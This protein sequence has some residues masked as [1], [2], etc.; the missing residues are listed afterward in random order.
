LLWLPE[1]YTDSDVQY[2]W[3]YS[4]FLIEIIS[5]AQYC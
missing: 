3:K 4:A 5:T 2:F 1:L